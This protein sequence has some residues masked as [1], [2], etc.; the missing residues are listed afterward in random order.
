M[1]YILLYVVAMK[2]TPS[3]TR[4]KISIDI[5]TSHGRN[6]ARRLCRIPH[7]RKAVAANIQMQKIAKDVDNVTVPL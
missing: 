5:I 4:P 6:S 7:V 3:A 2:D 1:E